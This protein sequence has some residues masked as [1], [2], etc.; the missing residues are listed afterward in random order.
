M[1]GMGHSLHNRTLGRAC[2]QT[3]TPFINN[4]WV[5]PLDGTCFDT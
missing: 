3:D 1:C 5:D 4:D 2:Y